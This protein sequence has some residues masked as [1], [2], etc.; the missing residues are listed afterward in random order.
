MNTPPFAPPAPTRGPY[1]ASPKLGRN[2]PCHCGSGKK[3][4]KCCL[5][6]DHR[7]P[8]P[9]PLPPTTPESLKKARE[10]IMAAIAMGTLP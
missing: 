8:E 1:R 3:Y 7:I 10:A 6:G 9:P 5:D 4:K 2:E